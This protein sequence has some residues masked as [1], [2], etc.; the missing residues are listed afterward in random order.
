[1]P[2]A[3]PL[4]RPIHYL[5]SKLR[6]TESIQ[7][8]VAELDSSSGAV[9]DLFAGSGTVALALSRE[10]NVI[11]ADIQEY[12]RV[13][14]TA[15]LQ[16]A[17]VDDVIVQ[18]LF[19]DV[20][21]T[22]ARLEI[23]LAPILDLERCALETAITRP[24]LLCELAEHGSLL[25][26][27][28]KNDELSKAL[29]ETNSRIEKQFVPLIATKYFGGIYFSYR[30]TLYVDCLL[31]A[32]SQLPMEVR[33][34][35][36]AAVLSTASTIVN[37]VGKQFAQPMRPRRKDGTIKTHL[38][39]QMCRDRCIDTGS[40]FSSWLSR[41]RQLPHTKDHRIIRGDFRE[42]LRKLSNVAVVYAD[43]P[44]T[45]DHYSRFYHVLETLSLG[46]SPTVSTTSLTGKGNASRGI[47]RTH[48]HQSPF[49]I[50]SQAPAAFDELF[51]GCRACNVPVLVSYSPYIKNG[52]PRLMT[53]DSVLEIAKRHYHHVDVKSAQPMT[54]SKLNKS[55]LHLEASGNAEVFI[56]CSN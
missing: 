13:L 3:P 49:C 45:R 55:E 53:V 23:C 52:H 1:M 31:H 16:P 54:H 41:Y 33:D 2:P 24:T 8:H 42:V 50:K 43:P 27:K 25:T 21:R 26:P 28:T 6:L 20:S 39:Q 51:R 38:I 40:V 11:A 35:C 9:C 18:N 22:H 44:Y 12:S 15:L 56:I 4:W 19:A 17:M 37:S 29:C 14:C 5:G 32:I 47:Y 30:Q 36:L 46:D 7:R 48:R 10:R 34:T